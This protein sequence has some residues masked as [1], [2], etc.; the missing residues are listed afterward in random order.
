MID[1]GTVEDIVG[2]G[3]RRDTNLRANEEARRARV[4]LARRLQREVNEQMRLCGTRKYYVTLTCT[5][6]K[7][8][9]LVTTLVGEVKSVKNGLVKVN[10]RSGGFTYRVQA[11]CDL[12]HN[13]DTPA[14]R[15]VFCNGALFAWSLD[16]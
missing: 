5:T 12:M 16:A 15:E 3:E 4:A 9:R 2:D 13:R 7:D 11:F 8:N 10:T 6:E 14:V 1:Y